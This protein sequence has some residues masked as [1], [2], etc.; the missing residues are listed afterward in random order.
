MK[1]LL[2]KDLLSFRN[3]WKIFLIYLLIINLYPFFLKANL[4]NRFQLSYQILLTNLGSTPNI[5]SIFEVMLLLLTYSFITFITLSQFTNDFIMGNENIFL[6]MS[7]RKFFLSK[8]ISIIITILIINFF[9]FIMLLI[10]YSILNCH[11]DISKYLKLFI[12]DSLIKINYSILNISL[13]LLIRKWFFLFMTILIT[14]GSIGKISI[15][16]YPFFAINYYHQ[17]IYIIIN[18]II[19]IIFTNIIYK[20]KVN[21]LFE[22]TD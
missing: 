1:Y 7:K 5:N 4:G 22:R 9:L 8:I 18:T 20:L 13:F 10:T 17:E 11:I 14:L 15:L 3:Y 21:T 2:I 16:S 6:R 12:I 19:V